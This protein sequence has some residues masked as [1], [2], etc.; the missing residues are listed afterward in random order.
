MILQHLEEDFIAT[1]P[2]RPKDDVKLIE[3]VEYL[4]LAVDGDDLVPVHGKGY[5][6]VR[7]LRSYAR[8]GGYVRSIH[9]CVA[10]IAG[11]PLACWGPLC[12]QMD[13]GDGDWY[14]PDVINAR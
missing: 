10:G 5:V 6:T 2:L 11:S 14:H 13:D 7:T 4:V 9:P 3:V 8:G 12:K 1:V